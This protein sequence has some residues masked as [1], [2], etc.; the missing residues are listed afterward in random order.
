MFTREMVTSLFT[1]AKR[2]QAVFMAAP[3]FLARASDDVTAKMDGPEPEIEHQ[4]AP[5]AMAAFLIS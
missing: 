1:P 5:A 2:P 4:V 3:T